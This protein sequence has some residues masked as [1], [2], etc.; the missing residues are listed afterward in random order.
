MLVGPPASIFFALIVV[1]EHH[2]SG[3]M[4]GFRIKPNAETPEMGDF[5]MA[6]AV[7]KVLS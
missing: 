6:H 4:F 7:Q 3:P 2:S 1:K 5:S